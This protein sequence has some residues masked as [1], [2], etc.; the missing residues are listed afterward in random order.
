MK[1]LVAILATSL[2]LCASETIPTKFTIIDPLPLE[3]QYYLKVIN[4]DTNEYY[5]TKGIEQDSRIK[6]EGNVYGTMNVI[7]K[8]ILPSNLPFSE[9]NLIR[10]KWFQTKPQKK[11]TSNLRIAS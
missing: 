8:Y 7:E 2:S 10:I 6:F 9:E 4:E 3:N 5:F 1:N 11:G